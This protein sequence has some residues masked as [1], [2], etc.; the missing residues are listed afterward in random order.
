MNLSD[1]ITPLSLLTM[2]IAAAGIW[3]LICR[4]TVMRPGETRL[5]VVIQH[6]VLAIGLFA[7][8]VW[9]VNWEVFREF[10]AAG[11][12]VDVLSRREL[13]DLV[14]VLSVLVFLLMSAHRWRW[15]APAG[16]RR[17]QS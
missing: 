4:I 13:G 6:F 14:L 17:G 5:Q 16:T 2:L 1:L 10:G 7:N 15:N 9:S 12:V 8:L 11:W 3:S